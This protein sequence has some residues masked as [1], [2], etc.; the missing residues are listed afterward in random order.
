MKLNNKKKNKQSILSKLY[1]WII[2]EKINLKLALFLLILSFSAAILT[3]LSFTNTLPFIKATPGIV[4]S[5]LTLDV[6]ILLFVCLKVANRIIKIW[7]ARKKGYVGSKIS[8]KYILVFALLALIPAASITIFS[9]FFFNLGMKTYFSD[10]VQKVFEQSTTVANAY[11]FEQHQSIKSDI[12]SIAAQI[13]NQ[14]DF[15]FLD[16]KKLNIFINKQIELRELTEGFVFN[17]K[18]VVIARAGFTISQ[19]ADII[20]AT[21]MIQAD[22][23]NVIYTSKRN[24]R[25]R[26]LIRLKKIN[27]T[28][29]AIG[30]FV[31]PIIINQVESVKFAARSYNH[32]LKQRSRIEINFY[33]VFTLISLLIVFISILIGL[34]FADNLINPISNLIHTS[35]LIRKGNLSAKV[36]E[37]KTN[38]E[39]SLLIKRF[40]EMTATLKKQQDELRKRERNTAWADI[41]RRIAHEIKNPLTPI[42]L[43]AEFLK[44]KSKSK[45]Y[46]DYAN[47]IVKQVST[48]EKM[49]DEFSN[50]ARLPKPKFN[51]YNIVDMCN[52]VLLL[53]KKANPNIFFSIKSN[54]PKILLMADESQITIVLNNLI[55]NSVESINQKLS[56]S[57][58]KKGEI[59]LVITKKIKKIIIEIKDNGLGLPKF[60]KNDKILEPYFTTKSNGTG[61]GL[62]IVL[63]IVDQHKGK[64][65]ISNNKDNGAL[66]LVELPTSNI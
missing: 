25:V 40:N 11:L 27:N 60:N 1:K 2:Y 59:N 58:I 43:S 18:G 66:S 52:Y 31:D 35:N 24:D 47:T 29:L 50:F 5:I 10:K 19:T 44:K 39:L 26:A 49:V 48:I 30:R 22:R 15:V 54:Q 23:G 57:N 17:K 28:Y 55:K 34:M 12:I 13:D 37:L 8:T 51:K 21:E 46:R 42:Q 33:I 41:A 38:D 63:R 64:F 61:L 3:F 45:E 14:F 20:T 32:L 65:I 56:N 62:A 4:I 9:S 6:I 7:I 36:P 53:H 16:L